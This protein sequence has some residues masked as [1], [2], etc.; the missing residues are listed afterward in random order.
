MVADMQPAL[1]LTPGRRLALQAGGNC[2]VWARALA[3]EFEMVVTVEP[4]ADN[5]H[6][7]VANTAGLP[8]ICLQAA[9]G[10]R[11]GWAGLSRPHPDN[12]GA[13]QVDQSRRA[14]PVLRIDDVALPALDYLC[15][16]VEGME[17]PVIEGGWQTIQRHRPV[18][19]CED[20]GLSRRYGHERGAIERRLVE[21][22][23]RVAARPHKDVILA[24]C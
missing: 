9:L 12:C 15:L 24:P 21:I 14:F 8:V 20:N 7:L 13:L 1:A 17:L 22:G 5:F 10:D 19:Q 3:A 2:G 23:Y 4:D 11:P 6:C 16:D 18:I